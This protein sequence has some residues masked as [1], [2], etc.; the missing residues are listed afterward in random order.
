MPGA[1]DSTARRCSSTR[2]PPPPP[3]LPRRCETNSAAGNHATMGWWVSGA[4]RVGGCQIDAHHLYFCIF[5]ALLGHSQGPALSTILLPTTAFIH[6]NT[7]TTIYSL[8]NHASQLQTSTSEPAPATATP[9]LL[10]SPTTLAL[11]LLALPCVLSALP[12]SGPPSLTTAPAKAVALPSATASAAAVVDAAAPA[13][14]PPSWSALSLLPTPAPLLGPALALPAPAVAPSTTG[15]AGGT[16]AA[17]EMA[18]ALNASTSD[19]VMGM[20]RDCSTTL[21]GMVMDTSCTSLYIL[22]PATTTRT[23]GA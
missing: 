22:T 13:P 3:P 21:D 7:Y 8:N 23:R 19:A 10:S 11:P 1:R 17:M 6:D 14:A 12:P 4:S 9:A 15:T 16:G 18:N 5:P 2:P 20:A